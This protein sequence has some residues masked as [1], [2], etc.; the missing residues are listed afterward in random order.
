MNNNEKDTLPK[1][2]KCGN[3]VFSN[4]CPY[5][6][7]QVIED[8]R[9]TPKKKEHPLKTI[10]LIAWVVVLITGIIL[11]IPLLIFPSVVLAVIEGFCVVF[12]FVPLFFMCIG[13]AT[14]QDWENLKKG[15]QTPPRVQPLT[16]DGTEIHCPTC[17]S[18]DIERVS[19]T[20]KAVNI[21]A[22][23]LFGN[24][25]NKQFKCKNCKYMW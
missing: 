3:T 17:G 10:L 14:P 6:H 16:K 18:T 1:C 23:G 5:C 24:K 7:T 21:W 8:K 19:L 9:S 15:T 2:S 20:T 4:T 12:G 22:F 25:R 11:I 13:S